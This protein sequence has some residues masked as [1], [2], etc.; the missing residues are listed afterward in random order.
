MVFGRGVATLAT[1]LTG[2]AGVLLTVEDS[3]ILKKQIFRELL[4]P[5]KETAY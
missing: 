1:V 3:T 2:V 4:E 5:H